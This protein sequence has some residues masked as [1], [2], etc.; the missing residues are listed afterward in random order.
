MYNT[1]IQIGVCEGKNDK[2][3]GTSIYMGT[4]GNSI[5]HY[6]HKGMSGSDAAKAAAERF[7]ALLDD[8]DDAIRFWIALADT[9][10]DYG[11]LENAV[12][13][14][15]LTYIN[16]DLDSQQW[17]STDSQN[18]KA[19]LLSLANK[20]MSPQP[21]EKKV[22][23]YNL[24]TCTWNPGD[25]F[26]Y[27]LSGEYAETTGMK[28]K[29]V[30]F[31]VVDKITW[32]PGHIIPVVYV[33]KTVSDSVLSLADVIGEDYLPQFYLPIAYEKDH[34]IKRL[35]RLSI[36]TKS[37]R[38]VPKKQLSYLGNCKINPVEGEDP[39]SY[40]VT[41]KDFEQYLID[42]MKAWE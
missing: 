4:W 34:T 37:A 38:S 33:Y 7:N 21:D 2:Q 14:K 12:K 22:R 10:W 26:A 28:D 29:Y 39:D 16:K 5:Y 27:R 9:Q 36:I 23:P 8:E 1:S 32:H 31:V 25:V 41:W 19:V 30:Y 20:L 42:D 24:Y 18:R 13:D 3:E 11:R 15:A 35:Y 6:I 17:L 40:N